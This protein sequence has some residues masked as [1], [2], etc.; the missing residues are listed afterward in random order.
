MHFIVANSTTGVRPFNKAY[1]TESKKRTGPECSF[2]LLKEV[3]EGGG[4]V[5]GE[6]AQQK[7]AVIAVCSV[8]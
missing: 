7:P 4:E 6:K 3:G 1:E 5:G 2:P 8:G